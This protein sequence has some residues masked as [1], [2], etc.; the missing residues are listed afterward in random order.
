MSRRL[1][2]L[3]IDEALPRLLASLER[4]RS[5]VLTAP[6]GAGKTTRVPPAILDAGLAGA[7]EIVVLEPRRLAA[8]MAA[9]RVAGERG[10]RVGDE[11]GYQVRFDRKASKQTRIRFVTEG[12]VGRQLVGDPEL[13]GVSV[14]V[15]DE[16]HERH[17]AGDMVLARAL[18]LQRG[19]RPDLA[20]V[21]MS[22]TLAAEPLAAYLDAPIVSSEGRAHPVTVDHQD[23]PDDRPLERQV[24][25]AVRQLAR[26][27]LDGHI[28]VF[29]PGAGEIRRAAEACAD[30]ARAADLDIVFLHGDLPPAEQDRA[31]GPSDRRKLILSTNV[32]ESSI[33]IDGVAAVIDSGL[34]RVARHSPWTGLPAL[35]VEPVSQASCAQRT[36]RAGR[37]GPGRCVRLFTRHDHDG[38]R[39]H[40]VPE[41]AR[42]DLAEA[43]LELADAGLAMTDLD[44][45]DPPPEPARVAA[46]ELLDR[47]GAT[48]GGRITAIGRRMLRL[49][50]HPRLAR[51]AVEAEARGVADD[52]CAIAALAGERE[53]RS[54]RRAAGLRGGMSA[55]MAT[56]PSDLLDDL[57]EL[58]A[59][60][61]GGLRPDAIR[62]AGLEP[63]AVFAA[64]R[65]RKQLVRLVDRSAAA[66]D[67][68]DA[69][70]RALLIAI[71]T[72]FPD[73]VARRRAAGSR[74]LVF[75]GG[76]GGELAATSVVHDATFMVC[77]RAGERGARGKVTVGGASEIDP[78]W[79][80]ELY[81]D[82]VVDESVLEWNPDRQRVERVSRLSYD[83][84]VLDE[85]RDPNGARTDPEA[86]GAI[87]ADA[88]RAAGPD[89]F[90]DAEVATRW[91][92]RLAFAA[93]HA[94]ELELPAAGDDAIVRAL[95]AA[96]PGRVSFAE[97]RQL[98]VDQLVRGNLT[99][100]QRAA[101]DRLAPEHVSIPGRRRV[102]VQY[103]DDRPPWIQSRLQDFFGTDDGPRIA[104]GRVPLVLHLLAP[105]RRAVQVTTDLA[106]FWTRHYPEIRK[107]LS[108]RYPKHRWPEDP[109]SR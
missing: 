63:G 73:R 25:A 109:H 60:R 1:S 51:I 58:D 13:S 39:E 56:G 68:D 24:S 67:G 93:E 47:L 14:I 89:R 21:A 48:A 88:V 107:Q 4:S 65:A 6:P 71:L 30:V 75:A 36:G 49:P 7:G 18:R 8:R 57:A 101:V 64:D 33:T 104:G 22:A 78:D 97:L 9:R 105:N 91:R 46:T 29:L 17:L 12:I 35:K 69:I 53:I 52:G 26:D 16:I 19:P 44:W 85:S 31:V 37:T 11:I 87:L 41:I 61:R 100:A 54:S 96:C 94:P 79:L 3:P 62:R 5:V 106:G 90:V 59:V 28:L 74:D 66:P 40:D 86:A 80:L 2:P 55:A 84:L 81:T 27:G 10:G 72:G 20:I 70:D 34:A 83:G 23:H 82:R 103:E 98:P 99:G 38:R 102:P 77:V 45:L 42:A 15:A 50:L 95:V 92:R 43:T 32:A 76:G 108:R